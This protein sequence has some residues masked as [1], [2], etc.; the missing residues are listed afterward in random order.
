MTKDE[1]RRTAVFEAETQRF[2]SEGYE[3][4]DI[5]TTALIANVAGTLLGALAAAPFVVIYLLFAARDND[6]GT[7]GFFVTFG[8]FLV[9]IVV[10]E[11]IHGFTWGLFTKNGFRSI[12]FGVIWEYLTPYC[13]CKEA[14]SRRKYIAGGV[15]PGI[16]LGII[17]LIVSCIIGYLPLMLYGGVMTICAGGDFLILSMIMRDKKNREE[18]FLDHPTKIG[19]VKFYKD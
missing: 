1:E 10:H 4:R 9:S 19:L 12:A 6:I 14:L 7:I 17:P 13:S 16:V 11:L 2:L 3:S 5:T 8:V 15:M 18:Y